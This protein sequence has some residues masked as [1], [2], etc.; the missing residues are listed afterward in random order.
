METRTRERIRER[1]R[2]RERDNM[3]D[4]EKS[5]KGGSKKGLIITFIIFMLAVNGV[6][7]FLNFNKSAQLEEKDLTIVDQKKDIEAK[8]T[9]L[10]A[11]I[12]ELEAK[13]IEL[14]KYGADTTRLHD[15]LES[16]K[17]RLRSQQ[18]YQGAYFKIK[19]ELE[20]IKFLASQT[21][22][23]LNKYKAQVDTLQRYNTELKDVISKNEESLNVL[24][25]SKE[26]LAQ[27]VQ[28][29]AVLKAENVQTFTLSAKGK[30]KDGGE[31][32]AKDIDLLRVSF[33]LGENRVAKPGGKE[34]IL[35][36][37]EPDGGALFDLGTGGGSFMF[38]GKEIFYTQKQDVIYDTKS[39]QITFDYKKGT[40]YK[41]G[42]HR[43][44]IYSD[45]YKIGE[46]TFNIK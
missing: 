43:I 46:S 23:E 32:K 29:A 9:E 41:L 38:E 30:E 11:A 8:N 7:I 24:K 33:L 13:K 17:E 25:S 3:N 20:N 1:E 44:E 42:E 40:P 31:Y 6:L 39:Q 4:S 45:G 2:Q 22:I 28:L 35:R 18:N 14:G 37:I 34:V 5:A 12:A 15:E 16:V 10:K 26:E 21:E 19:K 36:I 27:K